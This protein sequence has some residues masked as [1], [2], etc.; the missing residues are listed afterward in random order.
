MSS[1]FDQ[2]Q[3]AKIFS[4]LNLRNAYRLVRIREG[5]GW[6][7]GFNTPSGHYEYLLMPF[8][9]T[10]APAA[11]QA[12]INDVVVLTSVKRLS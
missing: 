11:S 5:D 7:I 4:K 2:P 12:M 10:N 3:Q 1:A 9:L 6:K 8:G